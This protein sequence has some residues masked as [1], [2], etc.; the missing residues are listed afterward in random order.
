MMIMVMNNVDDNDDADL[1]RLKA[2]R[3]AEMQKN[4]NI[5]KTKEQTTSETSKK[6]TS[7]DILVSLL[8]FRGLEVLES[9]ERQYPAESNIVIQRLVEIIQSENITERIDG[10]QLM[11]VFRMVGLP[12]KIKTSIKVEDDGKFVSLSDKL[13]NKT[14]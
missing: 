8:G 2:R 13:K 4:I 14:A 5:Q 3:L 7:R 12:V 6:V 10:G 1:Q 9:A 11:G